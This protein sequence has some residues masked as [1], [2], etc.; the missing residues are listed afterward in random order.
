MTK[1]I[2][3]LASILLCNL[4]Y[5]QE[6]TYL[7]KSEIDEFTFYRVF[8]KK[9][10]G[11]ASHNDC[12]RYIDLLNS[13]SAKKCRVYKNKSGVFYK[14]KT[15]DTI[16]LNYR[17]DYFIDDLKQTDDSLSYTLRKQGD[18]FNFNYSNS[19]STKDITAYSTNRVV[20]Y[21]FRIPIKW[22]NRYNK[23]NILIS[24]KKNNIQYINI[25]FPVLVS[26]Q[27]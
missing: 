7:G 13:K 18:F 21:H 14:I 10:P 6:I 23:G 1:T 11:Y 24:A 5:S 3:F 17:R 2:L 19:K 15:T 9:C 26:D 12:I 27:N 8:K 25:V 16:V 20:L 22:L 4:V